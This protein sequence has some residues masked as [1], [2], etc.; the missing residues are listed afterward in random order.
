MEEGGG[1]DP[2]KPTA[3]TVNVKFA[4]RNI[5]VEVSADATVNELKSL[6]QPLTNVLTRG[7][8]LISKG[9]LFSQN[10]C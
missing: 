1:S 4:G 6:L 2:Q 7:Q 5:P 10:S 3:I 8:K 9:S